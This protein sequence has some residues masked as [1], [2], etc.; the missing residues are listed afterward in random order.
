MKAWAI[1]QHKPQSGFTIVELAVVISV[2]AIL[3]SISVVAYNGVQKEAAKSAALADASAAFKKIELFKGNN[4]GAYPTSVTDCPT[5]SAATMCLGGSGDTEYRFKTNTASNLPPVEVAALNSRNFSYNSEGGQ[6]IGANEF[7]RYTDI[8][9][10]IDKYGLKEYEIEFDIRSASTASQSSIS[11]YFQN[12]SG[13]KYGGI[14]NPVPVT[15]SFSHYKTKFTA[16]ATGQNTTEAWIAFYGIYGSGNKPIVKNMK[17][18][19]AG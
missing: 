9:P 18:S 11:V 16:T 12:G 7:M 2:I 17:I 13:S 14:Y 3:A 8:A 4:N 15:T 1:Y 19:L 10:Y 6:A 5:P